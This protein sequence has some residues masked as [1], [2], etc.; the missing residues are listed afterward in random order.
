MPRTGLRTLLIIP[1]LLVLA[2]SAPTWADALDQERAREAM[3]AGEVAPLRELLT[4]VHETYPGDILQTELE[5]EDVKR[6]GGTGDGQILIYEIKLLTPQGNLV[7][8][9]YDAKTLEELSMAGMDDLLEAQDGED[10]DK[11][12]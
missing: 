1:A 5:G 3:R 10:S 9:K 8:L 11:N 7:K 2:L 12:D 4:I 6:W